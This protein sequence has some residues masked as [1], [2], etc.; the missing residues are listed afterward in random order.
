M[1]AERLLA[2]GTDQHWSDNKRI[3]WLFISINDFQLLGWPFSAI[4]C[5]RVISRLFVIAT[6]RAGGQHPAMRGDLDP[7]AGSDA[8]ETGIWIESNAD[9]ITASCKLAV[10]IS[11]QLRKPIARQFDTHQHGQWKPARRSEEF[12]RVILDI[13]LGILDGSLV[14]ELRLELLG[15]VHLVLESAQL[16]VEFLALAKQILGLLHQPVQAG[17]RSHALQ[18]LGDLAAGDGDPP[19]HFA[20]P[21]FQFLDL[22]LRVGA[23]VSLFFSSRNRRQFFSA[24]SV[25]FSFLFSISFFFLSF[26]LSFFFVIFFFPLCFCLINSLI[27]LFVCLSV[28]CFGFQVELLFRLTSG[29]FQLIWIDSLG[30]R[31]L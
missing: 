20:P 16:I 22:V 15:R 3:Y 10:Y 25:C 19:A 4:Y 28:C 7:I 1:S 9:I 29:T 26:F 13:L 8:M 31:H 17:P 12:L 14:L 23:P 21:Q 30:N 24:H 2:L 18:D 6:R 27:C 11:F 5:I